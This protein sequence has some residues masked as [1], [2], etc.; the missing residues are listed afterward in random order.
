M[1][2]HEIDPSQARKF[3]IGEA[4]ELSATVQEILGDPGLSGKDIKE[5]R[6]LLKHARQALKVA[7]RI[8]PADT[9]ESLSPTLSLEAQPP[10]TDAEQ[11]PQSF[12]VSIFTHDTRPA[13]D[14]EER[15]VEEILD[16][17]F[18]WNPASVKDKTPRD[19]IRKERKAQQVG[20]RA[21]A[22]TLA[23][24]QRNDDGVLK[25]THSGDLNLITEVYQDLHIKLEREGL[26]AKIESEVGSSL[27]AARG[28]AVRF[29]NLL[30]G[31]S[32]PYAEELL[33][34]IRGTHP[35]NQNLDL[36][37]AIELIC[38]K[39]PGGK[40]KNVGQNSQP[41]ETKLPDK[42]VVKA[43]AARS[44]EPRK[45]KRNRGYGRNGNGEAGGIR[46]VKDAFQVELPVLPQRVKLM[47]RQELLVYSLMLIS[48][49][50]TQ[51]VYPR[52]ESAIEDVYGDVLEKVPKELRTRR[53]ES[54]TADANKT[55]DYF[56]EQLAKYKETDP[57]ESP[58]PN[59]H[60]IV[61][62]FVEWV[63]SQAIYEA[64]TIDEIISV[65][66][67]TTSCNGVFETYQEFMDINEQAQRDHLV[68]RGDGTYQQKP[69]RTLRQ[70][71]NV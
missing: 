24:F 26:K 68:F 41:T 70:P 5:V 15:T 52:I 51:Y 34:Q 29:E 6:K 40:S 21:R 54:F 3:L 64:Y 49:S 48:D 22:I 44:P 10:A 31:K 53:L 20:H 62:E 45:K 7:G 23:L 69:R 36:K 13:D 65:L 58:E 42:T 18:A 37:E 55:V 71:V 12:E 25:F 46:R 2:R 66:S 47:T 67:R 33:K 32:D 8:I 19:K 4:A 28:I 27:Q 39:G 1:A 35:L 59:V 60:K 63:E 50:R 16:A 30:D 17:A 43:V 57:K 38:R 61:R 9:E 56:I 11:S 14:V